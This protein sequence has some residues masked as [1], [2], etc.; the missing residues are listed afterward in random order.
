MIK[1]AATSLISMKGFIEVTYHYH[2]YLKANFGVVMSSHGLARSCTED[3]TYK[4]TCLPYRLIH[5]PSNSMELTS[6][7]EMSHITMIPPDFPIDSR[8]A[9]LTVTIFHRFLMKELQQLSFFVSN[10]KQISTLLSNNLFRMEH[11][12]LDIPNP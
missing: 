10:R 3:A 2:W 1:V 7:I 6:K 8:K 5:C 9:H 11:R 4:P 12:L